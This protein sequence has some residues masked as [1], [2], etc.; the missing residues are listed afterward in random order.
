MG[1]AMY[2]RMLS[3]ASLQ[4]SASQLNI[5]PDRLRAQP[6]SAFQMAQD[7]RDEIVELRMKHH[8]RSRQRLAQDL[9]EHHVG[10]T[11]M[12]RRLSRV[13]SQT[14]SLASLHSSAS[15]PVLGHARADAKRLKA[16]QK[17]RQKTSDEEFESKYQEAEDKRERAIAQQQSYREQ[18]RQRRGLQQRL[19]RANE[20]LQELWFDEMESH[21]AR[22]RSMDERHARA[23]SKNE[24]TLRRAEEHLRQQREEHEAREEAARQKLLERRRAEKQRIESV[25]MKL[26]QKEE[27]VSRMHEQRAARTEYAQEKGRLV[28]M[29]AWERQNRINA[30]KHIE[31][32]FI[33]AKHAHMDETYHM[34]KQAKAE[35]QRQRKKVSIR[36]SQLREAIV[37]NAATEWVETL[38]WTAPPKNLMREASALLNELDD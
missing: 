38:R 12:S 27:Q 10:V 21:E 8:E 2:D 15:A 26:L 37:V 29:E 32:A 30:S 24:E 35:E 18:A 34:L 23:A 13:A 19:N 17:T 22:I 31:S 33:K 20:R 36:A 25:K 16:L 9:A 1:D 7:E 3:D 4:T 11:K 5:N 6:R 14:E 28:Q